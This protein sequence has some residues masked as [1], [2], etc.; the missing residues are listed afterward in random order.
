MYHFLES[1]I[2]HFFYAI[3]EIMYVYCH[4]LFI[5]ARTHVFDNATLVYKEREANLTLPNNEAPSSVGFRL[6]ERIEIVIYN[7]I[8]LRCRSGH[9]QDLEVVPKVDSTNTRNPCKNSCTSNQ[10]CVVKSDFKGCKPTLSIFIALEE[11][12]C[13]SSF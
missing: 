5:F 4:L 6:L 13:K 1:S 12:G 9:C 8:R 10:I 3:D 7:V 2:K 11:V